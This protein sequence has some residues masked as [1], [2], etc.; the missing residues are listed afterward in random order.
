M[1]GT[2]WAFSTFCLSTC[3]QIQWLSK[4]KSA[5][6][7]FLLHRKSNAENLTKASLSIKNSTYL[8]SCTQ[9]RKHTG[10]SLLASTLTFHQMLSVLHRTSVPWQRLGLDIKILELTLPKISQQVNESLTSLEAVKC[11]GCQRTP[12]PDICINKSL[13]SAYQSQGQYSR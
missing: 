8:S 12:A 7:A 13:L 2:S 10:P 4:T 1:S 6:G 5:N 9:N 11:Q 3:L